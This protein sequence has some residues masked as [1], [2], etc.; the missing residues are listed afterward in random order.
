MQPSRHSVAVDDS[1]NND[2]NHDQSG[3]AEETRPLLTS[4]TTEPHHKAIYHHHATRCSW[5]WLR[6]V[7]F[8]LAIAVVCDVGE[9][10]YVAPRIRLFESVVC[11]DYFLRHDPSLVD[12]DGGVPEHWC[13]VDA[14]QAKVAS[15]LGWQFFFDSVPAI[16]LPI[17][18][19]YVA[20][21]HG[22]K[23]VLTLAMFG[24]FLSYAW[25]LLAVSVV[26]P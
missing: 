20:D 10:L 16:L 19:G 23:W 1:I 22:R 14:V 5:P 8:A 6:I 13:K 21:K 25:T 9:S 26:T 15:I 3:N 2:N 11:R 24:Y 17:P 4:P 12:R 7:A 18:F